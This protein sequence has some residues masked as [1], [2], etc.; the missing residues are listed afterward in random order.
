MVLISV[1]AVALKNIAELAFGHTD[2]MM[3]LP[4]GARASVSASQAGAT[5]AIIDAAVAAPGAH[6]RPVKAVNEYVIEKEK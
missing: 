4:I 6:D 3:T 1:D 5:I 2:P